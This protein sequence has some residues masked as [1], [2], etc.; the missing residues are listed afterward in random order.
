MDNLH[1]FLAGYYWHIL[2]IAWLHYRPLRLALP[3]RKMLP[4][5][6]W[7][8]QLGLGPTKLSE[9]KQYFGF[10][11]KIWRKQIYW[12]FG[13]VHS[14]DWTQWPSGGWYVAYSLSDNVNLTLQNSWSASG[15]WFRREIRMWIKQACTRKTIEVTRRTP[16]V[17]LLRVYFGHSTQLFIDISL[18][19]KTC[20]K[21]PQ[22]VIYLLVNC[23]LDW[24]SFLFIPL[25]EL[26]SN[27]FVDHFSC[28]RLIRSGTVP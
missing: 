3:R 19:K 9:E 6:P 1:S 20:R 11:V 5:C 26:K 16:R 18:C 24:I 15:L 17:P 25:A 10:S 27:L 2:T 13:E 4:I 21:I 28:I 8:C 12:K 23:L 7:C 14:M 22:K